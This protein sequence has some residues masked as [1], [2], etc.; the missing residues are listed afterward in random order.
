VCAVVTD[1][2]QIAKVRTYFRA[3]GERDFCYVEMVSDGDEYCGTLPAPRDGKMDALEYYIQAIDDSY[4][5]KRTSTKS[6]ELQEPE[7]CGFPPVERDPARARAITV[8][9]TQREQRRL[10]DAFLGDG[11]TF[12]PKR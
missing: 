6:L 9:A 7:V 5:S 12:V 4:E 3:S 8:Y 1:D 10:D 2:S 11:V